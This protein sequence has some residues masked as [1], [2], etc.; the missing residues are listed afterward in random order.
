MRPGV[1]IAT[2]W[3]TVAGADTAPFSNYSI[4]G[5]AHEA[6]ET[7]W[8]DRLERRVNFQCVQTPGDCVKNV[9]VV[10]NTSP[11]PIHCRFRLEYRGVDDRKRREVREDRVIFPGQEEEA[12]A[13]LGPAELV[14]RKFSSECVIL[15][16]LPLPALDT[17]RECYGNLLGPSPEKFYPRHSPRRAEKGDVILEYGVKRFSPV[18]VDVLVVGSS[19][20]P[21]LDNA[22]LEY[23]KH[24]SH[25]HKCPGKRY[26]FQ[27]RFVLLEGEPT[28]T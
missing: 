6:G 12:A 22:A 23:A 13:S 7:R 21:D 15:P 27:V 28:R 9:I 24:L 10:R 5:S 17:P 18:L 14:P 4:A 20:Y 11:R 19:G 26:R 8:N 1:V 25:Q 16:T 2:M 3:V